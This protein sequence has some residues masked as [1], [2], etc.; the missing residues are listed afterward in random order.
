MNEVFVFVDEDHGV[1][2]VFSSLE[3][4][5][6]EG[7]PEDEEWVEATDD[8]WRRGEYCAIYR[9]DIDGHY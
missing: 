5:Q 9:R 4:A 2:E 8:E 3:K 1:V 6:G 7:W